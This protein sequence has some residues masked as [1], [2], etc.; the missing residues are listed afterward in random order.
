[1]KNL[2]IDN[3][4]N[5]LTIKLN[6][7]GFDENYLISLVKRLQAEELVQKAGFKSDVLDVAEQINETWWGENG[8]DFLRGVKK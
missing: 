3:K 4:G 1:M 7:K 5:Q 6:K 8:N 2:V